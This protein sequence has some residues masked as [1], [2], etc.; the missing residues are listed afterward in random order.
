MTSRDHAEPAQ[1]IVEG[2][3]ESDQLAAVARREALDRKRRNRLIPY[4]FFA[5]PAWDMLLA[6]YVHR[7]GGTSIDAQS[8]CDATVAAPTTALRWIGLLIEKGL[9]TWSPPA[10]GETDVR[11]ALT[12]AGALQLEPY[13]RDTLRRSQSGNS[14]LD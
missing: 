4:D 13:L 7:H 3:N 12:D 1:C 14:A 5:E 10:F 8:L 9:A 2:G 6:L 11:I